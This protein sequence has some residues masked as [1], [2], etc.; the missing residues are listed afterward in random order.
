MATSDILDSMFSIVPTPSKGE[1]SIKS[2]SE[3]KMIEVYSADG[4][5]VPYENTSRQGYRIN[6][7]SG[8]YSVKIIDDEGKTYNKKLLINR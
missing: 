7:P 8:V 1:F 5:T 6:A 3:I 2:K 4:V